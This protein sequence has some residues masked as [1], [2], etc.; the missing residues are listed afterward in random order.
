VLPFVPYY[1][2]EAMKHLRAR[3]AFL[4]F[5]GLANSLCQA[6]AAERISA[7]GRKVGRKSP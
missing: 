6:P 5:S 7:T 2:G 4:A 1:D 3:F